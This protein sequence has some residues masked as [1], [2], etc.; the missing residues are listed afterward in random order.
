MD[1]VQK[2]I[3]NHYSHNHLLDAIHNA[4]R[5]LGKDPNNLRPADLAP[6]DAF[7]I[8]GREATIELTNLASLKPGTLLLDVGGGPGSSARY[9]A[10]EYQCN[11]TGVDLTREYI[12]TAN[13]LTKQVGLDHLVKYDYG[14]ALNFL[15]RP[16]TAR[17][18][19][20]GLGFSILHWSDKSS[21]SLNWF[22]SKLE[23]LRQSGPSPLGIHLLMGEN[24]GVKFENQIRNLREDRFVVCQALLSKDTQG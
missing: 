9:L 18:I 15:I 22:V 12:D 3:E 11:V 7:H 23:T 14:N 24:A 17:D 13:V 16:D 10:S 4:L 2:Y 1:Q 20:T 21:D 6:V 8:R 5:K 19:L